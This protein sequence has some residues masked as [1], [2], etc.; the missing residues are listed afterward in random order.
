MITVGS[1]VFLY[2]GK[3]YIN[4]HLRKKLPAPV[5]FELILIIITTAISSI[6]QLHEHKKITIAKDIPTGLPT[7]H[8]PRIDLIP[9]VF[10]DAFEIAFVV[11]A[12][13]LSMCRLFN[14]RL[15]TKT[16]NN[17]VGVI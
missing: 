8:W 2:I 12:L 15:G 9:Y 14:R 11:V 4:P 7:A 16:D 10:G 13:H 17:Q 1:F 3:E 6:F 5:P